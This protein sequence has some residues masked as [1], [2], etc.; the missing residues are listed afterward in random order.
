[1][2]EDSLAYQKAL[3]RKMDFVLDYEA[4]ASFTTKLDV[5]YSF[6]R[7]DYELTQFVHKSGLVLAQIAGDDRSDF[8]LLPNRLAGLRPGK[9]AESETSESIVTKFKAFC[10][11]E[12]SLKAFYHGFSQ[13]RLPTPSPFTPATSAADS[14][15]PPMQL[16]P[17]R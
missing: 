13:L 3:L 11:D 9:A 8:L 7:P 16:P 4:A 12:V 5:S 1:M 2:A 10:R 6:G 15:V 14:D 17:L